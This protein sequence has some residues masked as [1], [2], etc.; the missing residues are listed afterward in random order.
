M[1]VSSDDVMYILGGGDRS[2]FKSNLIVD[3][4]NLKKLNDYGTANCNNLPVHFNNSFITKSS[5]KNAAIVH[6]RD[7]EYLILGRK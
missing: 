2:N 3:T 7:N 6:L 1:F 5:L 4:L